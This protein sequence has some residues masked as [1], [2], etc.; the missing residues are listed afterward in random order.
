MVETCEKC[1][2]PEDLCVCDDLEK[3][4]VE[5]EIKLEDRSRNKTVTVIDGLSD[6]VD[7]DSLSSELKTELACGGTVKNNTIELQGNHTNRLENI[8]EEKGYDVI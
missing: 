2:L 3:E 8:L 7:K 6:N 5:L 4:N 1:Q